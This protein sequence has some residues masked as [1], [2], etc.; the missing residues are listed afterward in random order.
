[1]PVSKE[2]VEEIRSKASIS[3]VIGH[4]IPLVKKGRG[5]SALCPFHDDHDPSLSISEEKQIFKCFVCGAGGNAFNFVMKYKNV[6]FV[7]AVA[8]VGEIVGI[9]VDVAPTTKR[10]DKNQRYYDLLKAAG[11]YSNYILNTQRGAAAIDYLHN[12]G[13][14]DETINYFNI[15]FNGSDNMMYK[16]LSSRN[17]SDEDM[18]R[19]NLV[20]VGE[21]GIS[22]TFYNR[23]MFPI[24]DAFNNPIAFSARTIDPNNDVKY[25]NSAD[26]LIYHK[27]EV[28]YNLNR[29]KEQIKKVGYVYLL[30]GVMDVIA[31]YRA[32]YLNSVASLGTALTR[33]QLVLL[34]QFTSKI[35]LFYDGDRAGQNAIVKAGNLALQEGFEVSV[36][37]NNTQK[38][39]DEII[40]EGGTHS[41]KDVVGNEYSFIEFCM[42]YYARDGLNNYSRKKEYNEII[43]RLIYNLPDEN[44]RENFFVILREKTGLPRASFD[45]KKPSEKASAFI[46]PKVDELD[47]NGPL[48]AEYNILSQV[49]LSPLGLEVYK[50][51]LGYLL[52]EQNQKLM[53]HINTYYRDFGSFDYSRFCQEETDGELVSLLTDIALRD[54]LKK[55]FDLQSLKDSIEIVKRETL[56]RNRDQLTRLIKEVENLDSNKYLEYLKKLQQIDKELGGYRNA[57]KKK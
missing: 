11:D 48:K 22:D 54:S 6:D 38:D 56:K 12:R 40:K 30:E 20:R 21:N 19:V 32:G 2:L 18:V 36:V 45:E 1:M 15:G 35:C 51:D 9:K 33:K 4:Y 27:G 14:D 37:H 47:F 28:L 17:F 57:K 16:F 29:A 8:E 49:I 50:K 26:T 44:D 23:V 53:D 7:Q 5:Y 46:T 31:M 39:P 55:E 13:L 41:L 3:E 34:R 52:D 25:I 42:D 24:H 43:S 10:I